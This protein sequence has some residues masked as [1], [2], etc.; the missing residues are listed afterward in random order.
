MSI[1]ARLAELGISLPALPPPAGLY[2]P[3]IRTGALVFISGQVPLREGKPML[4]GRCGDSVSIEEAAELARHCGLQALA[5]LQDHLGSLD[6]VQRVIRLGGFV[7][8]APGFNDQPKVINGAS[9]LM[10]DVFG[11]AGHHARAAVGVAELPLGVPVEV[12][13]L[14]EIRPDQA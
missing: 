12:E 2:V 3:A 7:A 8:S 10:L 6:R 13:F 11:E 1:D 4:R 5:I 14:F 9:Q